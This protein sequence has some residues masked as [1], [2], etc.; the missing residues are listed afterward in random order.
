MSHTKRGTIVEED[1][2]SNRARHFADRGTLKSEKLPYSDM[3]EEYHDKIGE[4]SQRALDEH[5]ES[6][7]EEMHNDPY[8][9][10]HGERAYEESLHEL[11]ELHAEEALREAREQDEEYNADYWERNRTL[12]SEGIYD[13]EALDCCTKVKMYMVDSLN[14]A[15]ESVMA[16]SCM[17]IQSDPR[18]EK[19]S[20]LAGCERTPQGESPFSYNP[21]RYDA[22][23]PYEQQHPSNPFT[24]WQ[25]KNAGE[26][27][28]LAFQLLK[29]DVFKG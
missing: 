1:P 3:L 23:Y 29:Y 9:Y 8:P 13:Y 18:Y 11:R 16:M 14:M 28:D 6:I 4:D 22:M 10:S 24:D 26:P 20:E 2:H 15:P 12:K 7:M 21:E 19:W 27:I 5:I 25:Q 17:K